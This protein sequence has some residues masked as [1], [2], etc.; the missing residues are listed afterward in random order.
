MRYRAPLRQTV[1]TWEDRYGVV[2]VVT[3][4]E[5]DDTQLRFCYYKNSEFVSRPLT[6]VPTPRVTEQTGEVDVR[7]FDQRLDR[8]LT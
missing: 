2:Q 8:D 3:P 1:D 7:R 6:I 5:N 4:E